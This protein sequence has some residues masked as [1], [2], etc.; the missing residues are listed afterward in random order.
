MKNYK[1]IKTAAAVALGASVITAALVPGSTS[2][3]AAS[4]YKVS[5][6]KLVN[7]KT[8]KVVKGYVVYNSKL[9]YNG[10]LKTGY[11][12]VGTGKSIKLYYNGSLKKGYKTVKENKL[13]FYNGSLKKGYKTAGNGERL[14]KD[15]YL[16]KGYEV[17]GDVENNPS[18]YYNGY[19]KSGYKTAN[20]AT[21][22]FYNGKLSKGYK[23]D[24]NG[25]VL[26]NEGRLNKGFVKVED[27]FY[28]DA[29]LANGTFEYEGKKIEV[30]D[31][32]VVSLNVES[33][34]AIDTT[35][36]KVSFSKAIDSLDKSA[37][38]VVN[39]ATGEKHVVKAV[40]LSEDKKS[41]T[42]EFYNA[43]AANTTYTVN[44]KIGEDNVTND[45]VIGS[46]KP[47]SVE[48]ANQTVQA[49]TNTVL[50]YK[51][52]DE[53]GVDITASYQPGTTGVS[54]ESASTAINKTT[55]VINLAKGSSIK[56]KVVIK[57]ADKVLAESSE[58]TISAQEAVASTIS[59]W[60]VTTS[61]TPDFS[62][63]AS[64]IYG[65]G[66]SLKAQAKDQLGNVIAGNFTYE[67]Q[68]NG[69]AVVDKTTGT[70]T[71]MGTGVVP[72][73]IS[74]VND[75]K[76]VD[77]KT[78]EIKVNAAK[79]VDS[80]KA[81]KSSVLL[82]NT[83]AD[84]QDLAV[85][86]KD[87]Y[88]NAFSTELNKEVLDKDGKALAKDVNVPTVKVES[89]A[90]KTG[91][92]TVNIATDNTTTAGTYTVKLVAGE[93]SATFKV[94]VKPSGEA[95]SYVAKEIPTTVDLKEASLS[96]SPK[97]YTSD[98]EGLTVKE[99]TSDA[100]VSVSDNEG[101]TVS[102]GTVTVNKEKVKAGD[103]FTVVVKVGLNTVASKVVTIVDTT[104]KYTAD[105]KGYTL[106]GEI[107][108]NLTN[109]LSNN[110]RVLIDGKETDASKI[111]NVKST[112]FVATDS[113]VVKND[114]ELAE[115]T[116]TVYVQ[117]ITL[118]NDKVVT[119]NTPV[120]FTVNVTK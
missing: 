113:T 103:T 80:I 38:E 89:V 41:A 29:E 40:T 1:L 46:L 44:T 34:K 21:L 68:N 110:V 10:K 8:G 100:A 52:K 91:E 37:F 50:D 17:Y 98:A 69:V 60:T 106:T 67:S 16:D 14:Y 79:A 59:A 78:V 61:V 54:F 23:T 71:P 11:K 72:V 95:T 53:S 85:L 74:L 119:F 2:A 47:S 87:Q 64:T 105:F 76:V 57:D 90:E 118:S 108:G 84:S 56:A 15:G 101:V 114:G 4:K 9:Y 109:L 43:F 30:K 3:F 35:S 75:G 27:K 36:A 18:L 117:E 25:T 49:D 88:G 39:K 32:M 7:A 65:S 28:N 93:K 66:Y 55:G 5:K 62:K 33:V 6:G 24:K 112:K 42:L 86:V 58:V 99:V 19:L 111:L 45:L 51:V 12:T 96:F 97:L 120:K 48:V 102:G 20:N 22:M 115:G 83:S 116:A 82:S 94:T 31:G 26:Y 92:Y 63:P 13:L 107:K 77:T 104:S 81:E 70:I 73:K